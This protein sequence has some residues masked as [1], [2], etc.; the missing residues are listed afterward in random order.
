MIQ[1]V[2]SPLPSRAATNTGSDGASPQIATITVET[3]AASGDADDICRSGRR[4]VR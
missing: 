2:A 3:V 1:P 4:S